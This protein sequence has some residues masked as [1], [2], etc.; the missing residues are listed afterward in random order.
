MNGD[1]KNVFFGLKNLLLKY[2]YKLKTN[3]LWRSISSYLERTMFSTNSHIRNNDSC[4]ISRQIEKT[5][6]W[7]YLPSNSQEIHF[8]WRKRLSLS[9][10]SYKLL[11]KKLWDEDM[12]VKLGCLPDMNSIDH[13]L[14]ETSGRLIRIPHR[15]QTS[16]SSDNEL[17]TI[18]V[19]Q[20]F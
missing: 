9:S 5:L 13:V 1:E 11:H 4:Q 17:E 2:M 3:V 10:E 18:A 12:I 6:N 15:P 16:E 14:A 7:T 20:Y 8:Y 19:R